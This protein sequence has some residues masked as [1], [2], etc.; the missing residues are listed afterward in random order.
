MATAAKYTARFITAGRIT[1]IENWLK[2]KIKG[3]WSFKLE[4][5]SEDMS[6]KS[7]VLMFD[8]AVDCNAFKIR[9]TPA[10]PVEQSKTNRVQGQITRKS[11]DLLSSVAAL[12]VKRWVAL[13]RPF[14]RD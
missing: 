9:F 3:N 10:K 8:D 13:G 6:K 4:S 14:Y 5:I 1:S 7:Y 12:P 2:Q 11:M